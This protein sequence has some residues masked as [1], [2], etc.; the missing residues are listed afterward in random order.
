MACN[1]R[2]DTVKI[3]AQKA[4]AAKKEREARLAAEQKAEA[5]RLAKA[6]EEAKLAAERIE[7]MIEEANVHIE[8]EPIEESIVEE[9]G[10]EKE[11]EPME[12]EE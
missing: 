2:L 1:C 8:E 9:D 11:F 4:F 5:E 12:G 7:K 3:R 10:S 6:E